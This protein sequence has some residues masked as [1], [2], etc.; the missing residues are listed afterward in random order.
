MLLPLRHNPCS[1]VLGNGENVAVV[2]ALAPVP[3]LLFIPHVDTSEA[4][5]KESFGEAGTMVRD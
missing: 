2:L 3:N 1:E 4:G 5:V